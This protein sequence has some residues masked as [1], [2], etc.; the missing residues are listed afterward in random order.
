MLE[1]ALA[2]EDLKPPEQHRLRMA[3]EAQLTKASNGDLAAVQMLADRLDGKAAQS[4][5]IDGELG[6]R[7]PADM[8]DE[9]L[10]AIANASRAATT[11]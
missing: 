5:T 1:R 10:A 4:L 7:K 8:T 3:I 2:Q 9:E 6:L 11:P